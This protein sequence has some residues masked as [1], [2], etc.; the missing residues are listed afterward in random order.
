M[1]NLDSLNIRKGLELGI[2]VADIFRISTETKGDIIAKEIC[3]VGW[4][5]YQLDNPESF[6]YI[7][8]CN[9]LIY[10]SKKEEIKI[11]DNL[12]AYVFNSYLV[13]IDT[14]DD[15]PEVIADICNEIEFLNTEILNFDQFCENFM[16]AQSFTGKYEKSIF[17]FSFYGYGDFTL[18]EYLYTHRM[19]VVSNLHALNFFITHKKILSG[20]GSLVT[21]LYRSDILRQRE[22]LTS[23]ELMSLLDEADQQ[24]AV[25]STIIEQSE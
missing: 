19:I 9:G 10:T 23:A 20:I 16:L 15:E 5:K 13:D 6:D 12:I 25:I 2:E 3:E 21:G 22:Y 14:S 7:S 24:F 8:K 17:K 11:S 1:D 18:E 4:Q